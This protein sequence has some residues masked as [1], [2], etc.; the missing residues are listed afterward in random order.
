MELPETST[1]QR[2]EQKERSV[3]WLMRWESED[4]AEQQ[5]HMQLAFVQNTPLAANLEAPEL[6]EILQKVQSTQ[7]SSSTPPRIKSGVRGKIVTS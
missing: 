1:L 4:G 3:T 7:V 6:G 5:M 2:C